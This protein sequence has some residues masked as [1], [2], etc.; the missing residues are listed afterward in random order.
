MKQLLLAQASLESVPDTFWKNFCLS[1]IVLIVICGI[2][3]GIWSVFRKAEPVK[4]NDD[5]AIE[6]R[7]SA[8]RFN[9]DLAEQRYTEVKGRLGEHD[10]EI[11]ALWNSVRVD[12]PAME[13]RLNDAGEERS[14]AIHDRINEIL[15]KVSELAG[16]VRSRR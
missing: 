6:V 14:G 15:A 4:L 1:L 7:K 5:P 2:L 10:A 11:N 8:K 12:I 3:V 13:R 9:H 16:E